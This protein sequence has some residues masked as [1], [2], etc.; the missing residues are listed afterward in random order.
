MRKEIIQAIHEITDECLMIKMLKNMSSKDI[1]ILFNLLS[2]SEP[3]VQERWTAVYQ[4]L[5]K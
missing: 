2:F 1:H 3:T 4:K 5:F